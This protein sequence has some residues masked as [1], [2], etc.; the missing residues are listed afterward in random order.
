[1]RAESGLRNRVGSSPILGLKATVLSFIEPLNKWVIQTS[2]NLAD[3]PDHDPY[4]MRP[5]EP[6]VHSLPSDFGLGPHAERECALQ[7]MGGKQAL[8]MVDLR[9]L[10]FVYD[11]GRWCLDPPS[12]IAPVGTHLLQCLTCMEAKPASKF[13]EFCFRD[14]RVTGDSEHKAVR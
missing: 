11:G 4:G 12:V 8:H 1:M 10:C 5:Q 9:Q 14:Y 6:Q 2:V 7:V 3:R 13:Q